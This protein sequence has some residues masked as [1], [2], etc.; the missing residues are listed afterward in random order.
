M[1]WHHNRTVT[2]EYLAER[3]L[4]FFREAMLPT[5]DQQPMVVKCVAQHCPS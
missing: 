2:R 1:I 5:E 4:C 3:Y